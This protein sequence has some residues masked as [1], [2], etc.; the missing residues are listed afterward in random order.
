MG[1][2]ILSRNIRTLLISTFSWNGAYIHEQSGMRVCMYLVALLLSVCGACD[3][4]LPPTNIRHSAPFSRNW[5]VTP[6]PPP[7]TLETLLGL[8]SSYLYFDWFVPKTVLQSKKGKT[9]VHPFIRP[10]IHSS[11]Q[12]SIHPSIHLSI[13]P[14]IHPLIQ[15]IHPSSTFHLFI[16]PYINITST[17][18]HPCVDPY[19][20][21]SIHACMRVQ[22]CLYLYATRPSTHPSTRM[23]TWDATSKI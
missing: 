16:Q 14:S 21:P 1:G 8:Q 2:T 10:S 6:P 22:P 9:T 7:H 19:I 13:H 15:P 5:F 12:S 20:N 17:S 18:V 3:S 4:W 11:I 23:Y